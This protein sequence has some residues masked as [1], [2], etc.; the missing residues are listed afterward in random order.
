MT[1]GTDPSRV[2]TG[3][4]WDRVPPHD[5]DAERC[6]LGAVLLDSE[7]AA[8]VFQILRP[9]QFY[10]ESHRKVYAASMELYDKLSALDVVL[11]REALERKGDLEAIGGNAAL[12][13][14]VDAVP[15]AANA[16]YYA[17][18][19]RD[20]AVRRDLI[21]R[22]TRIVRE[23]YE[24]AES[25]DQILDAAN[26]SIFDIVE[27]QI[28]GDFVGIQDVIDPLFD[29][30]DKG[31]TAL[32]G[33]P[34]GFTDLDELMNGLHPAELIVVAGRPSMGK[35]TFALNVALHVGATLG[36]PVGLFSLEVS[37]DQLVQNLLCSYARVDTHG[38]RSGR[39]S[40]ADWQR[41]VDCA[42]RLRRAPI[43]VDDSATLT[44][45]AMKAKAR[46]LKD[47][48]GLDLLVLDYLQLMEQGG[49][50]SRQEEISRISRALKALARELKIPVI[51]ISQLS[52]AVEARERESH[53]PRL[54]DLRESGAIEQ[55]ADV[56]ILLYR[57]EYYYPKKDEAKGKAE[58]IVA[59]QRNGPVDTVK[60]AFLKHAM[61]FEN[62]AQYQQEY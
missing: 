48:H 54:S 10:L 12:L 49:A 18:I 59:K 53:R 38:L 35:T 41:L 15:T 32:A 23:A 3:A 28:G 55:D 47:R 37:R 46:H 20:Q 45:T 4:V 9:D 30:L 43:F 5:R 17:T 36:R 13:E 31:Q 62:L 26:R 50:N 27:Q 42:D 60:L 61:R 29:L 19:V 40:K 16:E 14:L 34:T 21:R 51:A 11:V 6:V 25:P 24:S 52:R 8:G 56:V 57:E 44:P 2:E 7:A 1:A 39:L 33:V 58:V 22:A